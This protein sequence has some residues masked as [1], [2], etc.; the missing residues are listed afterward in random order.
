M[1]VYNN[2]L[3]RGRP[4]GA[5]LTDLVRQ[6]GVDMKDVKAW[7]TEQ[8]KSQGHAGNGWNAP[9]ER[10]PTIEV[11]AR[12]PVS[13]RGMRPLAPYAP[14]QKG[15]YVEE[16]MELAI[17]PPWSEPPKGSITLYS[18]T[19]EEIEILDTSSLYDSG[20]MGSPDSTTAQGK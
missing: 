17:V 3:S 20:D 14:S 13:A 5:A 10:A 7:F 6:T 19:P 2:A 15:E 16:E 12:L 18:Y 11:R 9:T 4:S 8:R 1:R